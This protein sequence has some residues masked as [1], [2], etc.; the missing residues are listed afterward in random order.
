MTAK[1]Q[2]ISY[3]HPI[4]ILT[5]MVRMHLV[6]KQAPGPLRLLQLLTTISCSSRAAFSGCS[7]CNP[8]G[9]LVLEHTIYGKV[10][11]K[12]MQL[13]SGGYKQ[14]EHALPKRSDAS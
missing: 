11:D 6:V 8:Q 3:G 2:G 13:G 7:C 5:C 14:S 10:A 1:Q 12:C 4:L 9:H